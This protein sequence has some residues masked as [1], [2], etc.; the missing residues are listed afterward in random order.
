M[1]THYLIDGYNLLYAVVKLPPE[2]GPHV[3]EKARGKLLRLIAHGHGEDAGRVTVVF[4]APRLPPGEDAVHYF[5]GMEIVFAVGYDEA[6]DLIE[7]RI[8]QDSSP[9]QLVVV[10][11][12][13]R[14]QQAARHRRCRAMKCAAY[15]DWLEKAQAR[16]STQGHADKKEKPTAAE[17]EH[18]LKEFGELENDAAM[19][20]LFD[21]FGFEDEELQ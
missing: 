7:E 4:D 11:D 14:L 15:L 5:R 18:W 3:L 8:R 21:P 16:H 13:H 19:K 20:E 1:S 12:D 6:D 17:V 9:K 10:S 2:A